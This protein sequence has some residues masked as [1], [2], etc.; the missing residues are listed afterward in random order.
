MQRLKHIENTYHHNI[1]D[2][3]LFFLFFCHLEESIYDDPFLLR[4][5]FGSDSTINQHY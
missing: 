1:L 2:S 4:L 5:D 3:L